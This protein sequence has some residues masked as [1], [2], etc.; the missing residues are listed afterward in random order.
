MALE[1]RG[2]SVVATARSREALKALDA[3]MK[4]HLDVDD[5]ASIVRAF[6]A[7]GDLDVVVNNAGFGVFGPCESVPLADVRGMFETNF[8]GPVR[9]MQMALPGMR[10]RNRGLIVNVSSLAGRVSRPLSGYYAAS[11]YALEAVSEAMRFEVRQFGIKI[12]CIEPGFIRSSFESNM[13][14]YGSRESPYDELAAKVAQG[15][16]AIG[17][18][19][20][21][22]PEL[23][24]QT[25]AEAVESD[26]PAL[27]WPVGEDARKLIDAREQ[28]PYPAFERWL[29]E[30]L[31]IAP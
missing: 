2:H 15:M 14:S 22:G 3:T 20:M 21:P 1:S 12:V 8:F 13:R 25:I 6:E 26:A 24:A 16:A 29:S 11:K 28:M 31:G 7:A 17:S 18:L 23:V 19:E 30:T 4:L 9:V 10:Q 27:H 5:D